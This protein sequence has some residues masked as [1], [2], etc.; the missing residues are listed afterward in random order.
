VL[1]ELAREFAQFRM[2]LFGLAMVLIMLWRP[3]GL[4]AGR[5]PSIRLRAEAGG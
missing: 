2:L 3:Q 4:I 1:P 5:E